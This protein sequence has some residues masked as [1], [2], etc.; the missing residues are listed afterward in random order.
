MFG[1]RVGSILL[2]INMQMVARDDSIL[3]WVEYWEQAYTQVLFQY[4][5]VS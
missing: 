5:D 4:M 2:G 1:K 3:A